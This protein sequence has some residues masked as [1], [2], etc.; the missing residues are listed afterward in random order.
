MW[1]VCECDQKEILDTIRDRADLEGCLDWF[2]VIQK[3]DSTLSSRIILKILY[4]SYVEF[5]LLSCAYLDANFFIY[6][7]RR[8]ATCA[9]LDAKLCLEKLQKCNMRIFI[10]QFLLEKSCKNVTC[11]YSND[12]F[13]I[14]KLK[15]CN[16]C[17]FRC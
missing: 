6:K 10:C 9:Y 4:I 12:K 5:S 3:N 16:M 17:I 7:L 13:C 11:A 15:K 1:K 14:E 2:C 8:N